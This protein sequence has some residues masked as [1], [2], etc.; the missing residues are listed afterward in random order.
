MNKKLYRSFL[1]FGITI[2]LFFLPIAVLAQ[3]NTKQIQ[4]NI[5]QIDIAAGEIAFEKQSVRN[6]LRQLE[7][8]AKDMEGWFDQ[9]SQ[10]DTEIQKAQQY[11]GKYATFGQ[12]SQQAALQ[13]LTN[14]RQWILNLNGGVT[15]NGYH[16]TSMNQLHSAYTQIPQQ[17]KQLNEHY[18]DLSNNLAQMD[19]N[20]NIASSQL[21]TFQRKD[22][23]WHKVKAGEL[24]EDLN[25]LGNLVNDPNLWCLAGFDV[26]VGGAPPYIT[27]KMAI[28]LISN[29]YS[30]ELET[31]PG[32][33]F[34]QQELA[35]RIITLRDQS[36]QFKKIIREQII[37][38]KQQEL[39]GL[40]RK[41]SAEIAE[42]D[43]SNDISGC[44]VIFLSQKNNPVINIS[45]QGNGYSAVI[46]NSGVLADLRPGHQLFSVTPVNRTTFEGFEYSTD[47]YGNATSTPLQLI[48]GASGY[49]MDYRSDDILSLG[50]CSN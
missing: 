42:Q 44:W 36:S 46:T 24:Q 17:I 19:N 34:N 33:K 8:A 20:R 12:A 49:R 38:Q 23:D 6:S 13:Q 18:R 37:P 40:Q 15:I 3:Y 28:K 26:V 14:D 41:I 10:I 1:F 30:L 39:A 25:T 27:R 43:R 16:Y 47:A 31:T 45:R 32:K 22:L 4:E 7:F 9:L 11:K 2:S 5:A 21:E 50:R 35:Q 48:L 29:R